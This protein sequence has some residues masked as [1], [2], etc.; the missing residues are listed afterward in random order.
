MDL[1]EEESEESSEE[2][3][4]VEVSMKK[5]NFKAYVDPREKSEVKK[6]RKTI[7][8]KKSL[9]VETKEVERVGTRDTTRARTEE[10]SVRADKTANTP[11]TPRKEQVYVPLT[12]AELMDEARITEEWNTADLQAYIKYTELS[13]KERA[14]NF[15]F[16]KKVPKYVY[17]SFKDENNEE[18]SEIRMTIP[19]T[20]SSTSMVV[21]KKTNAKYRYPY[22]EDRYFN[23]CEEFS[24]IHEEYLELEKAEIKSII[25]DLTNRLA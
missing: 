3:V 7:V 1:D 22:M 2:E 6:V 8:R 16:S 24:R 17:R 19:L 18:R 15:A 20:I 21:P 4:E 25:A 5:R 23:T 12:H 11:K 14:A 10:V 13:D 9:N